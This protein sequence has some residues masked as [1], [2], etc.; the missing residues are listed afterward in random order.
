MPSSKEY[1]KKYYLENKKKKQ[2]YYKS[3]EGI[4]TRNISK[5]KH[6]G[7][8]SDDYDKLYEYY[9]SINNCELCNCELN[10]CNKSL[11]CLDH[12]HNTGGFRNVLCK[13][14]NTKIQ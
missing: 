9:L 5:W 8:L 10:L 3:P 6:R 14:C 2:E 11:K 12:D 1:H 4:K 13:G 7:V